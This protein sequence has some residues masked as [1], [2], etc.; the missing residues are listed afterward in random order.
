M[1]LTVIGTGYVGLTSGAMFAELGHQVTCVDKDKDKVKMLK[2]GKVPF[3]EPGLDN[4]VRKHLDYN[5][6]FTTSLSAAEA[7]KVIM[8]AV[9][10]PPAKDGSPDLSFVLEVARQLMPYLKEYKV[11]IMKSTVPI[12]TNKIVQKY[13]LDKGVERKYFDIVSNPEFIRE[14]TAIFDSFHPDRIVIGSDSQKATE[15]TRSL[16]QRIECPVMITSNEAAEMIKYASNA[17]LAVKISFVNELAGICEDY[18]VDICEV[19]RGVGYDTRIGP[20]FLKAGAGF[21]GSCLP[22]DLS[23]L[24]HLA[25]KADKKAKLLKAV[26]EVNTAQPALVIAKLE[27]LLGALQDKKIA[28]WGLSFKPETDDMRF[29]PAIPVINL[30]LQKQALVSA[31]DPAAMENAK[32]LLPASVKLSKDMYEAVRNC[33]ALVIMTEWD[34]FALADIKLLKETMKNP[35]IVDGRNIFSPSEMISQGFQYRG[36]GR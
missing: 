30:L 19:A 35:V 23:G 31:F 14:G 24:L 32:K 28:V 10:T 15:I 36:I 22:K 2:T 25:D 7:S 9:G 17:F 26:Y 5:I 4:L 11:I 13:L 6:K 29:A 20:H 33:D 27:K 8:I 1:K 21:G 34:I 3:Y 12:G 18:K 16:Y